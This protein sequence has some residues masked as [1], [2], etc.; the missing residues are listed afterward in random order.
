MLSHSNIQFVS[1]SELRRILN[2]SRSTFYRL[3]DAGLPTIGSGRRRRH[4][5]AAVLHWYDTAA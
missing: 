2:I 5:L 1:S 4:S 3:L